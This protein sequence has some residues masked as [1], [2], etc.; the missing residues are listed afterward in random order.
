MKFKALLLGLGALTLAGCMSTGEDS[1]TR[2]TN[3]EVAVMDLEEREVW[4][5]T[6]MEALQFDHIEFSPTIDTFTMPINDLFVN[7]YELMTQ[8]RTI[9]EEHIN[10]QSFLNANDG[11]SE[12]ELLAAA[13]EFD[14]MAE[15]EEQKI[16]P[17]L[18]RYEQAND[19]I[20]SS[21]VEL[22]A[23]LALQAVRLY[24]LSQVDLQSLLVNE[25][26]NMLS[27]INQFGDIYDRAEMQLEY[28]GYANEYIEHN[29]KLVEQLQ[30][31]Q[32]LTAQN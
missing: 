14:A 31:L 22:G 8:Y 21:N 7:Q 16:L 28:I 25:G 32:G 19:E 23:K 26:W 4:L 6:E 5:R 13:Q 12:E 17:S 10:V 2:M 30:N 3:E 24:D 29:Q 27:K 18:Q 11:K 9:Q 15:S 20:F 1:M